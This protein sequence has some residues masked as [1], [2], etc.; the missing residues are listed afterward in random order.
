MKPVTAAVEV[1]APAE[2]VWAVVTDIGN[3]QSNIPAIRKVEFLGE[4]RHGL[5]TRWRETRVMFGREAT[6]D[7]EI[8]EWRPPREYVVRARNHG[9][10]YCSVVRVHARGAASTLEFEFS[11]RPLTLFAKIMAGL[12][13]PLMGKAIRNALDGDLAAL[14]RRCEEVREDARN[15]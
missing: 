1:A 14:K 8:T 13:L 4:T 3:A 5:G 10:D 12:T 7:L 9:C 6:E 11:A 2:R 15:Q